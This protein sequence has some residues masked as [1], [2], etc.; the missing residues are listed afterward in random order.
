MIRR[1]IRVTDKNG[2]VIGALLRPV[3][4]LNGLAI[5]TDVVC[6]DHGANSQPRPDDTLLTKDDVSDLATEYAV[7]GDSLVCS[8]CGGDLSGASADDIAAWFASRTDGCPDCGRERS[9]GHA[10]SCQRVPG[11]TA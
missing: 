2:Q 10:S 5:E 11:G 6:M 3:T 9:E 4:G 8:W 7:D 1:H